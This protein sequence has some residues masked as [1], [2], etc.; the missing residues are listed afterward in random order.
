MVLILYHVPSTG[1]SLNKT[2][3]LVLQALTHILVDRT[4]YSLGCPTANHLRQR[5]GLNSP[6][7][8]SV[9][10][11]TLEWYVC[12]TCTHQH[13]R[14]AAAVLRALLAEVLA[15][16]RPLFLRELLHLAHGRLTALNNRGFQRVPT[17]CRR[18]LGGH[19]KVGRG[20]NTALVGDAHILNAIA[21]DVHL[22]NFAS[23]YL[24]LFNAV[25]LGH[26]LGHPYGGS[27]SYVR[28]G[29]L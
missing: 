9:S 10:A 1:L 6:H 8:L 14:R 28:K 11:H 2:V 25:D 7:I 18:C 26:F 3:H 5:Y 23:V 13:D 21:L 22:S 29:G 16:G 12:A 15:Q 27:F 19:A 17:A 4:V 20:Q 24:A